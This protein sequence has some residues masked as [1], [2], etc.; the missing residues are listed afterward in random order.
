MGLF[1]WS[2]SAG[3]CYLGVNHEV[4]VKMSAGDIVIRSYLGQKDPISGSLTAMVSCWQQTLYVLHLT[5]TVAHTEQGGS[6]SVFYNLA[7]DFKQ[8]HLHSIY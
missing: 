2:G 5:V 3:K 1:F 8:C 4:A 6:H 7:S